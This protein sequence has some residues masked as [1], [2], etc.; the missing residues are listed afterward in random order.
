MPVVPVMAAIG[1]AMGATAATVAAKGYSMVQ[2][3]KAAKQ[4]A[5]LAKDTAGYNAKVDLADAKQIELDTTANVQAARRDAA[6]YS[7]RQQAAYA[8]SGVYNSGSALHVQAETA[9]RLEQRTLQEQLNS[10]QELQ[11]RQNSARLFV[12]Y[13]DAAASA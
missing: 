11:K 6:V 13:G 12:I 10:T 5:Q 7:S 1:T 9:G 4:S 8:A 3:N 2:Q